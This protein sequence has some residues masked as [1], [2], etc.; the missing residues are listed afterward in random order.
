M[1]VVRMFFVCAVALLAPQV[2][3]AQP[4]ATPL[5]PDLTVDE[6]RMTDHQMVTNVLPGH[7]H[8]R[9]SNATPN[10][11][12]GPLYLS[13]VP[14]TNPND[15]T[16]PVN[17]FIFDSNGGHT[18][19]LAGTFEYHPSHNHT[20]VDDWAVYRLREVLEADG[21]G[22]IVAEGDKTSFCL[23]DTNVYDDS[24][25]NAAPNKFFTDC[26][27][28]TQGISVGW[29]D[30]YTKQVPDQWIDITNVPDG[31]YWLESVVDPDDHMLEKD[32]TNNTK[33]I[34]ITIVKPDPNNNGGGFGGDFIAAILAFLQQIIDFLR[35][36]FGGGK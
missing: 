18:E 31:T 13:A 24:L 30:L 15:T 26:G 25:P 4:P 21:V 35:G 28:G 9:F 6:T 11:G 29:E 14:P 22:D 7:V 16:Q 27:N 19:R 34:K 12:D 5:L 10:I 2:S 36:L 17:Q 1:R 8:L 32:E 20:H 33:R 23:L 3:L